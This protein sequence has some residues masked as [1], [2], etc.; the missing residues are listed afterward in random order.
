MKDVLKTLA[1][2]KETVNKEF[3]QLEQQRQQ[4]QQQLNL[5][6]EQLI[7]LTGRWQQLE[8]LEKDFQDEQKG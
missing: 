5:V 2:Q 6:S 7:K 8:Q 4:L 1:N 3:E